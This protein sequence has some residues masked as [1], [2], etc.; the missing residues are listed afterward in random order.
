[1]RHRSGGMVDALDSK[2]SEGN[3]V[4]VRVPPPVQ[5]GSRFSDCPFFVFLFKYPPMKR[6]AV[7][8]LGTNGFRLRIAESVAAGQFQII[9]GE[10]NELKLATE[11][12][13]RIGAKPFERGV[14]AMKTFAH[15]IEE[16]GVTDVLAIGTATLR[17]AENGQAF[18]DTVLRETGI[19]VEL[20][21]GDREADFIYKGMRLATPL[22]IDPVLMVDVGGG[23]VEFIICN[24]TGVFWAESF[25][26]GVQIL[27][28]K[29]HE[30][31]VISATEIAHLNAF[32][33]EKCTRLLE[34]IAIYKPQT[35][36][37]A[38]GTLD[39]LVKAMLPNE[40]QKPLNFSISK[41]KYADFYQN[42]T[43]LIPE[44]L[45]K[46]DFVSKEK[47]EML[48]V[49]MV[50]MQWI[51]EAIDAKEIIVSGYSMKQGIMYEMSL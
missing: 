15:R 36:I 6:F 44:D 3:L 46:F 9:F 12:I 27:K 1:M 38:C 14:A 20:I 21:S 19:A 48:P 35:P 50:L 29:F 42:L 28:H 45:D 22:S 13:H 5:K 26:V 23:S 16:W 41:E 39:A 43:F 17:L 51:L 47:I 49:S 4:R 37:I 30:N 18:I 33:T 32:L 8:D 24:E 10:N 11:G 40:P 31:T 7:I 25:D 34:N 2:S